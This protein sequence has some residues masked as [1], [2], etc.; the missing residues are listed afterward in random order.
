MKNYPFNVFKYGILN[1]IPIQN[2]PD[3]G[4][5]D[6]LNW[7]TLNG[8]L[9]LIRGYAPLGT[10]Q[11]GNG[12]ITGLRVGTL[13][14]GTQIPFATYAQKVR[15]YNSTA[16]EW[17]EI[18][19]N[20]LP[21]AANGEDITLDIFESRAGKQM[22]LNSPNSGL[23]KI[24]TANPGTI[25]PMYDSTKNNK[26]WI[27]FFDNQAYLWNV[28]NTDKTAVRLSFIETRGLAD[29]SA[30]TDEFFCV[31]D[32]TTRTFS[33][34]LDFTSKAQGLLTSN[35]TEV[36]DSDTVTIGSITY[37][38]KTTMTA[39]YDVKRSGTTAITLAS[40]GAAINASGV[41]GT[42]Y[43]AGTLANPVAETGVVT[44]TTVQ[45][46]A[47]TPGSAGNAIATTK[48]S[49]VLGWGATTLT[50]GADTSKAHGFA[51]NIQG[52]VE[53]FTDDQNGNMVGSAGGT[54]TINYATGFVTITFAVAPLVGSVT[55]VSYSYVDE[56]QTWDAG[57]GGGVANF[58]VPG[59]RISGQP[60]VFR[61]DHGGDIRTITALKDHK[62]CI[63]D[64]CIYDL[65]PSI[66]DTQTT[67]TLFREN[68]GT[69]NLRGALATPEGIYAVDTSDPNYL[70]FVLV[71]YETTSTDIKPK[72]L[73]PNLDLSNFNFDAVSIFAF[74]DYILFS[75]RT[76]DSA[77]NNR[78]WLYHRVYHTF[79]L[80][81]YQI[82]CADIYNGTLL[83]GDP[84]SNNVYTLFSGN[85]ADGDVITNYWTSGISKL[86]FINTRGK[87]YPIRML[88]KV[89]KILIEGDIGPD[90]ILH[91][92]WSSDRGE[93]VEVLDEEG[94]PIISGTGSYVDKSQ[95]VDVGAV[96]VGE[97]VVGNG[98]AGIVA[99]HYE[100]QI[101]FKQS[102][103]MDGQFTLIASGIGYASVINMEFRDVRVKQDKPARKY[104]VN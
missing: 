53:A 62:F 28:D 27:R 82:S 67:N 41:V 68:I 76:L 103:F 78:T 30:N 75:C 8:K 92:Y 99:Y 93:M 1:K 65:L 104:R 25:V 100:R 79:D 19:S 101:P 91:L 15:Y 88:K 29:Y 61:Q 81:D 46:Y 89:K 18:G 16:A 20:V 2:I 5:Y 63:H 9:E 50:G 44:G 43:F 10:E 14:N 102:K 7:L 73:S 83:G 87:K 24:I 11:S 32:G 13:A 12:R 54:G 23:F 86:G 26:G 17:T 69:K 84:A 37:R 98:T 48:S 90:Q 52:T 66:D 70:R 96:T 49:T 51:V 94:D 47:K 58:I 85:D 71:T 64:T 22:W 36:T 33:K 56:T 39:A 38:F 4:A 6:S 3:G 72:V 95:S 60:N 35:G 97:K 55:L 42:D 21:A 59:D 74:E 40:L 31:G 57:N 45:V 80:C 77:T 34:Y